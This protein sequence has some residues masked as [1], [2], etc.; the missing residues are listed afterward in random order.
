M[1]K[2]S[3]LLEVI[4]G[5]LITLIIKINYKSTSLDIFK[6]KPQKNK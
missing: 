3:Y 5:N 4:P 2:K 1:F 6:G